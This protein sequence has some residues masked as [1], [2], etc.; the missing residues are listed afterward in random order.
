MTKINEAP[1]ET[2]LQTLNIHYSTTK[3][4]RSPLSLD[5]DEVMIVYMFDFCSL[6]WFLPLSVDHWFDV[7]GLESFGSVQQLPAVDLW[8]QPEH[9][10]RCSRRN[11]SMLHQAGTE[12]QGTGLSGAAGKAF[13][14]GPC[15]DTSLI[16]HTFFSSRREEKKISSSWR[17]LDFVNLAR[18]RTDFVLVIRTI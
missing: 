15:R 2:A 3:I 4:S 18:P 7:C 13:P 5:P 11:G 8:Q 16:T 1:S 14:S 6:L 10:E 12:G 17:W 9:Q